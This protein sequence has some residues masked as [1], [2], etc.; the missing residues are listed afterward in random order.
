MGL[1]SYDDDVHA[2]RA[3]FL[4]MGTASVREQKLE[5]KTFGEHG[6]DHGAHSGRMSDQIIMVGR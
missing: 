3:L 1:C 5:D 4:C 2:D 6:C